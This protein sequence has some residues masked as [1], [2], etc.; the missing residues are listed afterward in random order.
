[1]LK[2]KIGQQVIDTLSGFE[3][4]VFGVTEWLHGCRHIG[5]KP[6]ELNKDGE[7]QKIQWI[8]EPQV[9]VV[10]KTKALKPSGATGGPK[11]DNMRKQ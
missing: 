10:Q 1:M 6:I 9:V 8:D 5:I 7:P 4:I 3:G 2:I 11:E